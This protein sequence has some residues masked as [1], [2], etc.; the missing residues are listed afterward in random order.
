VCDLDH[1]AQI[2]RVDLAKVHGVMQLETM[3][4]VAESVADEGW[5]VFPGEMR[6]ADG[7]RSR[8]GGVVHTATRGALDATPSVEES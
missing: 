1:L 7:R 2:I 4:I 8:R 3:L 6:S 5:P